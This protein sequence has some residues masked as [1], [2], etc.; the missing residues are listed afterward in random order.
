VLFGHVGLHDTA[1]HT[2]GS[3]VPQLCGGKNGHATDGK[4][5]VPTRSV[6]H[7]C[8]FISVFT[9]S[10]SVFTEMREGFFRP[11]SQDLVFTR[12]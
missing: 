5:L 4:I 1:G 6:F 3:A 8:P 12:N 7:F 10:V 11:F 9:S 2:I